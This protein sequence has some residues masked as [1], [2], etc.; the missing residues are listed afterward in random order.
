MF[1]KINELCSKK[2]AF[3]FNTKTEKLFIDA[4]I[5]NY[6]FQLKKQPYIKYLYDKSTINVNTINTIDE[7]YSIPSLFVETMKYHTFCSIKDSDVHMVLKS[8]GTGGQKTQSFFDKDSLNRLETLSYN[9]FENIGYTDKKPVHYFIMAYDIS[10]ANNIG[11]SWSDNF[12]M[13]LAPI[14]SKHWLIE[15]DEKEKKY[16]FDEH[17]WAR[18]FIELSK[19]APIRLLG[20]PA[21]MYKLIEEIKRIHGTLS[22]HEDSF[23]VAGGGWKNHLG[24]SMT[25]NEFANYIEESINLPAKNIGDTYGMAEHGVPYCSCKYGHYHIP[26]YS[27]VLVRDPITM[28]IQ[29]IG[30]K[31][32][33]QLLTPYNIAQPN[34]SILS[35]D[36]VSLGENCPCGIDGL[37][38]NSISR[39]GLKKHKGCSIAAQEILNQRRHNNA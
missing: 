1:K 8:S 9:T 37:Y 14:K 30:Q 15:W 17:K 13:S 31:G 6:N 25:L 10:K 27:R 33:L 24:K 21:Y 35:K 12:V 18:K 26:I 16:F 23:I 38:I 7:I 20:F 22:V 11:T 32:L 36:I 3:N 2:E 34:L 4:M 39:G 5:E 28:N 29:P 19:D